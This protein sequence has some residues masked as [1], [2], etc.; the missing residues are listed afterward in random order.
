M[1]SNLKSPGA[2]ICRRRSVPQNP[3]L[4]HENGTF[5]RKENAYVFDF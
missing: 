5:R 4:F 2:C 1:L 3:C